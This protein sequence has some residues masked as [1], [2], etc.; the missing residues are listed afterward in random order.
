MCLAFRA[1]AVCAMLAFV[2]GAFAG[3]GIMK[4]CADQ[5]NLPY[6]NS[7]GQGFEN[8]LAEM[9]ARDFGMHLQYVW[10]PRNSEKAE[11]MFRDGGCDL[12]MEMPSGDDL[13]LAT[14]P[15]YR[16]SYVFVTRRDRD[17]Q[18]SSFDDPYLKTARIGL[19][20]VSDGSV[21]PES[22]LVRRGIVRNVVGYSLL[23]DSSKPNPSQELIRAVVRGEIDVAIAW[24]PLAGYLAQH[25][26]VPLSVT[27][28]CPPA[29]HAMNPLVFSISMGV[30]RGQTGLLDKLNSEI[31]RRKSEIN[32]ILADYGV[33][34]A[35]E[36]SE[37]RA[38]K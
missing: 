8:K 18:L 7:Q 4:V 17:I 30:R 28:I 20:L 14:Q 2:P 21:P 19:H 3:T 15:Y 1:V 23:G 22:E 37:E 29:D 32:Q 11:K 38:C 12:T 13:A 31:I 27:P 9:V 33:P 5:N 25:S 36:T 24:G 26:P 35:G 34:L 10:W 16:S 6:S